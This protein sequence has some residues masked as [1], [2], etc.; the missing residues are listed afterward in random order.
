MRWKLNDGEVLKEPEKIS[1]AT[2]E[3]VTSTETNLTIDDSSKQCK[4]VIYVNRFNPIRYPPATTALFNVKIN[5]GRLS[6]IALHS[7]CK[8]LLLMAFLASLKENC[9]IIK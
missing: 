7:L 5:S 2:L 4:N 8:Q 1:D 3:K 6:N 9:T